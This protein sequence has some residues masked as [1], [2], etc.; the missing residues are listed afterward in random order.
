MSDELIDRR[1][2]DLRPARRGAVALRL[3]AGAGVGALVSA[4]LM[5]LLLGPRPDLA[6][7]SATAV[8]WNKAAYTLALACIGLWAAERL[9]RPAAEAGRQLAWLFAPLAAIAILALAQLASAPAAMRGPMILGEAADVCPWLILLL[10][11]PP[12]CGL[13]SAMRG[14]GPTRLRLAGAVVGLAAAGAGSFIYAIHCGRG[15]TRGV[16]PHDPCNQTTL[17]SHR[18]TRGAS[19]AKCHLV[20]LPA[21]TPFDK[22]GHHT[23]IPH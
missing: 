21:P 13:T 11:V 6:R 15:R 19:G 4:L 1:C 10:S 12:F 18:V 20:C 23:I 2:T 22:A 8:F 7:A 5:L 16:E 17:R 3:A 14:L 9:V